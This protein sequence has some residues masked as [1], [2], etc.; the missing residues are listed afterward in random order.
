MN[1]VGLLAG[2]VSTA[3][4]I[5]SALPMLYKAGRTKDL[6]SYSLGNIA[7]ANL[8]NAVYAIYVFSMPAGPIWAMHTFYVVSSALMLFWYLRYEVSKRRERSRQ[9]DQTGVSGL[10]ADTRPGLSHRARPVSPLAAGPLASRDALRREAGRSDRAPSRPS[11]AGHRRRRTPDCQPA[12]L[13]MII[14]EH[15]E[16]SF[17]PDEERR[18]AVAHPLRGLWPAQCRGPDHPQRPR[19]IGAPIGR[20][21]SI[22]RRK[23]TCV[24]AARSCRV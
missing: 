17:A 21:S 14:E 15:H 24:W 13:V 4:F 12:I 5:G 22:Q 1:S 3:L 18:A 23:T 2:S 11:L 10:P 8:G 19:D 9:L 6:G 20:H 16:A 7:L